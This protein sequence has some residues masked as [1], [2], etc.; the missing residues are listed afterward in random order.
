MSLHVCK[1]LYK[2]GPQKPNFY[3][4]NSSLKVRCDF[5][6]KIKAELSQHPV[7]GN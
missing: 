5:F 2:D 6:F 1:A 4:L 7:K 3:Q